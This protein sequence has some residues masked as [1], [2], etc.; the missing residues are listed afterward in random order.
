MRREA[1]KRLFLLIALSVG[2]LFAFVTMILFLVFWSQDSVKGYYFIL[3]I[4]VFVLLM[5]WPAKILYKLI[6]GD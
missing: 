3:G 6:C 4:Q 5:T 2:I 1:N